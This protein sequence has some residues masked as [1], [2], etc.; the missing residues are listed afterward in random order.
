M[1]DWGML[2]EIRDAMLLSV[3]EFEKNLYGKSGHFDYL[4]GKIAMVKTLL[5]NIEHFNCDYDIRI[6]LDFCQETLRK[7]GKNQYSNV[8]SCYETFDGSVNVGRKT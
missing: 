5:Q 1:K 8:Q 4:N 3:E 2:L 7:V 6:I